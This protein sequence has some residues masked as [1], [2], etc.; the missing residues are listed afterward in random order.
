MVNSKSLILTQA[1]SWVWSAEQPHRGSWTTFGTILEHLKH[2][3]R[4]RCCHCLLLP[5]VRQAEGPS[6]TRGLRKGSCQGSLYMH[7][8]T[9]Q[10]PSRQICNCPEPQS[11]SIPEHK[12]E[13][14]SAGEVLHGRSHT[15]AL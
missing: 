2:F 15:A 6:H 7:S 4:T 9:S 5:E 3:G 14:T 11:S 13:E 10:R 1:S 12:P 8:Q